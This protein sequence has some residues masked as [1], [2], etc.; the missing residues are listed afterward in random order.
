MFIHVCDCLCVW[1][2]RRDQIDSGLKPPEGD[3]ETHLEPGFG[4]WT[5]VCVLYVCACSEILLMSLFD[6]QECVLLSCIHRPSSPRS[7]K[8]KL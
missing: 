8:T 4:D 5:N 2:E 3:K 7:R 6:E 1:R